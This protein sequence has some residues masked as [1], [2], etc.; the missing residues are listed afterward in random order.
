M[1]PVRQALRCPRRNPIAGYGLV[2][3]HTNV[4]EPVYDESAARDSEVVFTCEF[5]RHKQAL[6]TTDV[7][8]TPCP[9][10]PM[11]TYEC[12][13][14]RRRHGNFEWLPASQQ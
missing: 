2:R 11:S 4:I 14:I 6:K 7:G 8:D 3:L 13:I 1:K 12:Q 5:V 10:T 9:A